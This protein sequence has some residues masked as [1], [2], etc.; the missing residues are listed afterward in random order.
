MHKMEILGRPAKY[1]YAGFFILR[2]SIDKFGHVRTRKVYVIENFMEKLP[3]SFEEK[4][5]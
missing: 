3:M 4:S 1:D 5:L 2:N